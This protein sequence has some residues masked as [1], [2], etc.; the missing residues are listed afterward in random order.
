MTTGTASFTEQ[1]IA[2]ADGEVRVMKAGSG[3]ALVV[4]HHE[5][6]N[7][8]WSEFYSELAKSFTVYVP[9]MPGYGGSTRPEWARNVRDLCSL[10]GLTVA[11]LGL[12]APIVVGLGWGGWLAAELAGSGVRF[13]RLVLV[14]P[15]GIFPAEGEIYD[16]FMVGHEVYVKHGFHSEDAFKRLYG[17]Q[18]SIEQLVEWDIAREMTTRV[19]WK[20][21]M[22]DRA[23]P[24]LLRSVQTPT[25]V[26][27]GDDSKV[28]P[29]V[30]GR[31]YVEALPNAKL[32]TIANC[33]HWADLEQ[34]AA[35]AK[36]TSEFAK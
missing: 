32:A 7:Q 2:V 9:D 33:G 10:L 20:P 21:Y 5:I 11:Q 6:G 34:P 13:S 16:Q 15:L 23:L 31:Q 35:L 27:W 26:V 4:F 22:F 28:V 18:A 1:R 17:D 29:A 19:G 25:L 24:N 14:N 8:G 3:P 36:L 12:D 30:C